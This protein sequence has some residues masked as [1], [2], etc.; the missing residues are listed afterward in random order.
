MARGAG[1]ELTAAHLGS[2]RDHTV[3]VAEA[4]GVGAIV[5]TRITENVAGFGPTAVWVG[6]CLGNEAG[7][8]ASPIL[9]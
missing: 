7:S 9:G 4:I 6:K 3:V 8:N 1:Y 2:A 5:R